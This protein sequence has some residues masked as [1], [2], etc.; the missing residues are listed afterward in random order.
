VR[1]VGFGPVVLRTQALRPKDGEQIGRRQSQA[2]QILFL[3][4]DA[5]NDDMPLVVDQGRQDG[6]RWVVGRDDVGQALYRARRVADQAEGGDVQARQ[7]EQGVVGGGHVDA[8]HLVA[9]GRRHGLAQLAEVL[10]GGDH[11]VVA[12]GQ[13]A[14]GAADIVEQ[15]ELH[16][17]AGDRHQLVAEGLEVLPVALDEGH[18]HGRAEDARGGPGHRLEQLRAAE[19]ELPG[20]LDELLDL[21][22]PRGA[23]V[24]LGRAREGAAPARHIDEAAPR[25]GLVGPRGGVLIHPVALGQ[26]AHCGHARP[27]LVG[28]GADLLLDQAL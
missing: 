12:P 21:L 24:V 11:Q 6:R 25:E 4:S 10:E 27:F 20:A 28:A 5:I 3:D 1:L 9:Q 7:V 13:L 19:A 8:H 15:D 14:R 17:R 26:L 18:A 16:R 22:L 23:A 2:L